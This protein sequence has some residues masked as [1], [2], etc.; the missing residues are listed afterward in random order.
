MDEFS[1][2]TK[3]AARPIANQAAI[4]LSDDNLVLSQN[5]TID[6]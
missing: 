5:H 3:P 2:A 4:R 1:S 6:S